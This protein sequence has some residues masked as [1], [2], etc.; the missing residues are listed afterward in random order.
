[1]GASVARLEWLLERKKGIGGSDIAAVCGL[2]RYRTPMDVWYDKISDVRDE[3]PNLAMKLGTYLEPL[4]VKE[5]EAMTGNKVVVDLDAI[6][7]ERYPFA[8]CNLDGMVL[9]ADGGKGV[10]EVKTAGSS[11][12]WGAGEEE[13]PDEYYCQVQWNMLIAGLDWADVPV[14]FFDYGRRIEIYTIEADRD[15]QQFLVDK[16]KAFWEAVI[17]ETMP[18]PRSSAEAEK[19]WPSHREGVRQQVTQELAETLEQLRAIKK[20]AKELKD[21]QTMLEGRVKIAMKDAERL[22]DGD[23]VLCT[24]KASR[25]HRLDQAALRERHPEIVKEFTKQTSIRRFLVK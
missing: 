18:D 15:F 2:N 12:H 14:L 17:T 19:A 24:W 7:H 23:R 11:R 22:V 16:A 21:T 20:K 1:M 13:I 9:A 25:T 8:R 6:K 5:Y 4:I 3:E 10:L